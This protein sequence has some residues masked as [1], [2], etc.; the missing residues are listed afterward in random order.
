[1]AAAP[2]MAEASELT[3]VTPI[4]TVARK[5]SGSFFKRATAEADLTPFSS[6]ASTRLLRV[7]IMAISDAAKKPFAR[8]K[9]TIRTASN[10]MFSN[11][12]GVS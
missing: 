8:I 9:T 1:M 5:R 6:R 3:T 12:S 7:A 2:P 10:H 4:C 11:M